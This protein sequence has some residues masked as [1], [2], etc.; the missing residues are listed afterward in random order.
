M[1][2]SWVLPQMVAKLFSNVNYSFLMFN[3]KV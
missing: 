3:F 2:L 1:G